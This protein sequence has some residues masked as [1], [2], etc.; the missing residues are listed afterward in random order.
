MTWHPR[1]IIAALA[2]V[3]LTT[4]LAG[5]RTEYRGPDS[6]IDGVLWRQVAAMKDPFMTALLHSTATDPREFIDSLPGERWDGSSD[7]SNLVDEGV[8]IVYHITTGSDRAALSVLIW[9]GPRPDVPTD[10]GDAYVGP[11][12]VY[13]CFDATARFD[14]TLAAEVERL[15]DAECASDLVDALPDDSAH[16]DITVFSG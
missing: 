11:G 14:E 3:T 8:L 13:T 10:A 7:P 5:C 4:A 1:R 15:D 12:S 9:S 6:G 16:A 2:L